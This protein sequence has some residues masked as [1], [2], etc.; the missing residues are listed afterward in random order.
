MMILKVFWETH[1]LTE[2]VDSAKERSI[3]NSVERKLQK[4]PKF[5]RSVTYFSLMWRLM[6][7]R[8]I[9]QKFRIGLCFEGDELFGFIGENVTVAC[10]CYAVVKSLLVNLRENVAKLERFYRLGIQH[11]S[12]LVAQPVRN[13]PFAPQDSG[14]HFLILRFLLQYFFTCC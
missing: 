9:L 5:F 4:F 10:A 12:F 2:I 1:K 6:N 13:G 7:A 14:E 3:S 8:K 11:T